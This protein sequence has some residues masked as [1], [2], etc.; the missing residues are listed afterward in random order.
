M[1]CGTIDSMAT[2]I[3]ENT[4]GIDSKL[5]TLQR[6]FDER[7]Q[8]DL[9]IVPDN[10]CSKTCPGFHYYCHRTLIVSCEEILFWGLGNR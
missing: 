5:H 9:I 7:N 3:Q 1:D 6:G 10:V 4:I 2:T 8:T